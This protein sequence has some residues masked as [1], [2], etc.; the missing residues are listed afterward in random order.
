MRVLNAKNIRL[1]AVFLFIIYVLLLVY[2]TFL[3]PYFGRG[4]LMFRR[5][6]L[7]PFRTIM[8]YTANGL[9]PKLFIINVMGNIAA[10]VPMGFLP[11][12]VFN[13]LKRF[14]RVLALTFIS[15]VMVETLQFILKAGAGDID[16]IIL[17]LAG[18]AAGY[19]LYLL[20]DTVLRKLFKTKPD[21]AA[22]RRQI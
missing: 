3:S 10:F 2:L 15:T 13:R 22:V 9:D 1:S 20:A 11:P 18:G 16:D 8:Q 19:L 7:V 21:M 14:G 12:I 17:N 6:N 5:I 4:T